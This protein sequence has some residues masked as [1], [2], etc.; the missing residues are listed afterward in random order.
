MTKYKYAVVTA[1]SVEVYERWIESYTEMGYVLDNV[2]T[3]K[4]SLDMDEL[5]ITF[6]KEKR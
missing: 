1:L 5:V 6:K 3:V 2:I 4:N